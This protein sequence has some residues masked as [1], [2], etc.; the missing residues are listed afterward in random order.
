MDHLDDAGYDPGLYARFCDSDVAGF[1]RRAIQKTAQRHCQFCP[2]IRGKRCHYAYGRADFCS[3]DAKDAAYAGISLGRYN[4]V[5]AY[6][7]L[8]HPDCDGL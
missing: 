7:V 1:W 3:M 4:D 5:Y 8:G 2:F 6:D